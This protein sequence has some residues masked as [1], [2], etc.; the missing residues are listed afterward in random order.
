MTWNC[1]NCGAEVEEGVKFCPNC[2][3]NINWEQAWAQGTFTC[4]NCGGEFNGKAEFCPHCGTKVNWSA[5]ETEK[6]T[7]K[8]IVALLVSFVLLVIGSIC[9]FYGIR[10]IPFFLGLVIIVAPLL[11]FAVWLY[12]DDIQIQGNTKLKTVVNLTL[13]VAILYLIVTSSLAIYKFIVTQTD[14]NEQIV[15]KSFNDNL[16]YN[17]ARLFIAENTKPYGDKNV[18]IKRIALYE[19]NGNR[20]Y[21]LEGLT[22]SGRPYN[23]EGSWSPNESKTYQAVEYNY[24]KLAGSKYYFIDNSGYVYYSSAW[25]LD[26]KDVSTAF[27]NGAVAQ[28]RVATEE[29]TEDWKQG[30]SI[31]TKNEKTITP[32]T[33]EEKE[34]AQA[35]YKDGSEFALAGKLA[36]IGGLLDLADAVGVDVELN[37]AIKDAAI[38]DYNK[39]YD[40][41][42]TS[43][44][45]RLKDIYIQ[46][47]IEGFMS[48]SEA[49]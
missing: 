15:S 31:E 1:G 21:K 23:E 43:K 37:S 4:G 8:Q 25:L 13:Y 47:Y 16:P 20:D 49:N 19:K 39:R 46:N 26:E 40:N 18:T 35:G 29:E 42:T 28:L 6:L 14:T 33:Q 30:K 10:F 34:Y 38:S 12:S 22:S 2:G 48:N 17:G 27:K 44:Q 7:K 9:A 41:P 3:T 24:T 5:N 11:P 32:K 36:G 45:K